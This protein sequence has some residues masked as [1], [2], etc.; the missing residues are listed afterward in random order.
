[1]NSGTK[2]KNVFLNELIGGMCILN[3]GKESGIQGANRGLLPLMLEI[4]RKSP[5][6]IFCY[7]SSFFLLSSTSLVSFYWQVFIKYLKNIAV[8]SFFFFFSSPL[9]IH[10][11]QF[12]ISCFL[13]LWLFSELSFAF[14]PDELSI[15]KH[16][17]PELWYL[18]LSRYLKR[19]VAKIFK[20]EFYLYR[21]HFI[22][23]I[24]VFV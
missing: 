18:K 19:L 14:C 7:D 4:F 22:G 12:C 8:F 16:T 15:S 5:S 20:C 1:M 6:N 23:K 2:R 3:L 17:S 11:I 24:G 9:E 10:Q 21:D 13:G